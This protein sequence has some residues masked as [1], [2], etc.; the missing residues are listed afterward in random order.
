[1][2]AESLSINIINSTNLA[3][4]MNCIQFLEAKIKKFPVKTEI[5]ITDNDAA[6]ADY[7][8][9][10]PKLKSKKTR[11]IHLKKNIEIPMV[12]IFQLFAPKKI[13]KN[14]LCALLSVSK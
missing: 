7:L 11:L 10:H 5:Y 3:K 2:D 13:N 12:T 8:T 14:R 9:L 6:L 4:T 1:M